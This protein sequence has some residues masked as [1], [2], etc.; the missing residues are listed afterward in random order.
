[1]GVVF[2]WSEAAG[3][4]SDRTGRDARRRKSCVRS[5]VPGFESDWNENKRVRFEVGP[6]CWWE[7]VGPLCC[8]TAVICIL[9]VQVQMPEPP[10]ESDLERTAQTRIA[11]A[12]VSACPV[13]TDLTSRRGLLGGRIKHSN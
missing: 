12:S 4:M 6:T 7:A 11:A 10:S 3:G 9:Q 2:L 5:T 8:S 13:P 1:M